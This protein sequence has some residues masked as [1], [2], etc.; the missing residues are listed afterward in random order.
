MSNF[1]DVGKDETFYDY[2]N[3]VYQGNI[4]AFYADFEK[5]NILC[6]SFA[7]QRFYTANGHLVYLLSDLV[8][9]LKG[10]R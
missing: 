4:R 10:K 6:T 5:G 8:R 2:M 9:E 3:R 1:Q 7:Y